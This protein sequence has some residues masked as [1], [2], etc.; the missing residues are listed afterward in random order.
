MLDLTFV[1][2]KQHFVLFEARQQAFRKSFEAAR[3]RLKSS[4]ESHSKALYRTTLY[5]L[6]GV[7]EGVL[8]YSCIDTKG[9]L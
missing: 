7:Y 2:T 4:R 3:E 6:S 5:V 9:V 8:Y 1:S